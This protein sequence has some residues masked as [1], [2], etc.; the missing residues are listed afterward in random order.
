MNNKLVEIEKMSQQQ[1]SFNSL[2]NEKKQMIERLEKRCQELECRL[3]P[4]E[5]LQWEASNFILPYARRPFRNTIKTSDSFTA[6]CLPIEIPNHDEEEDDHEFSNTSSSSTFTRSVKSSRNN[7]LL[8]KGSL[9]K[10]LRNLFESYNS[11]ETPLLKEFLNKMQKC[12]LQEYEY[13]LSDFK[14]KRTAHSDVEYSLDHAISAVDDDAFEVDDEKSLDLLK[15]EAQWRYIE[16]QSEMIDH[17]SKSFEELDRL[18]PLLDTLNDRDQ[19]TNLCTKLNELKSFQIE[20]DN[21][22]ASS[23]QQA[24]I[25]QQKLCAYNDLVSYEKM[26]F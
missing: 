7:S 21:V 10:R 22:D 9:L 15:R 25:I 5:M 12:N 26:N 17:L 2:G 6:K 20:M 4:L 13:F 8:S 19:L 16:N 3:F 24:L 11:I 23:S 14:Q 1:Q 18:L